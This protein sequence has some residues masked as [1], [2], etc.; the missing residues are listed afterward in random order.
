MCYWASVQ[1][2]VWKV[3]FS[4][5]I[6]CLFFWL[7]IHSL[8]WNCVGNTTSWKLNFQIDLVTLLSCSLSF[9]S[10]FKAPYTLTFLC[11]GWLCNAMCKCYHNQG[12][13][14]CI[15]CL[16]PLVLFGFVLFGVFFFPVLIYFYLCLKGREES[17]RLKE[18]HLPPWTPNVHKNRPGAGGSQ[19]PEC[20]PGF[21]HWWKGLITH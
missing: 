8:L 14:S 19:E 21:S 18:R 20:N 13:H 4:L 2:V 12:R 1:K 15:T 6:I 17:E 9:L 3:V 16:K 11:V 10:C 7:N 5:A